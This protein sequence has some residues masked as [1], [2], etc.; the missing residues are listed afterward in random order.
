MPIAKTHEMHRRRLGRNLGVALLLAAFI[1][2][3]FGLTVV[4]ISE[5]TFT[6]PHQEGT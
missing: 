3:I 5:G 4:K 1:A 2:V 6:P